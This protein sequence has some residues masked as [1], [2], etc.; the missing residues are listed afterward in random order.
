MFSI[1]IVTSAL[2]FYR[3]VFRINSDGMGV[4]YLQATTS[5]TDEDAKLEIPRAER[6][7]TGKYQIK[8]ENENGSDT[9]EVPVIV[10]GRLLIAIH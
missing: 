1:Q 8:V 7:D 9:A 10:L 3:I 6:G 5:N 2:K 4:L